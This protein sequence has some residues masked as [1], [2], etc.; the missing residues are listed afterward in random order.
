MP[1]YHRRKPKNNK[2][3]MK[4]SKRSYIPKKIRYV[5]EFHTKMG[6]TTNGDLAYALDTPS[7][8]TMNSIAMTFK[9]SDLINISAYQRLFE[10]VR[11]NKIH[12][13]FRPSVTQITT[14]N[15][16]GTTP[17]NIVADSVPMVYYLIDRNDSVAEI[18]ALDFKEYSK[19]VSK[20]ATSGHSIMFK[21]S[22]LSPIYAGNE[23]GSPIFT[24][25]VD[26]ESKWLQLNSAGAIETIYYGLK[27][28]IEGSNKRVF[29][30]IPTVT[31]Y[32]S[33]R[34]KRE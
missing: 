12:V 31:M 34:G 5:D 7:Y 25:A 2:K 20:K 29:T 3:H 15:S 33:F 30:I 23:G 6:M 19:T 11:V 27:Y 26:Y 16:I 13:S 28:G 22:T 9:I 10:E 17:P 18:D 32:L 8:G 4:V 1:K 14:F 21:P 24:Y